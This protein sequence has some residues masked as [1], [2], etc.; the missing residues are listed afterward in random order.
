MSNLFQNFD[1]F[2]YSFPKPQ[3]LGAK[4]IHRK[5]IANEVPADCLTVLDAFA[6]SQS[7]AYSLKQMG[8]RVLTNDFLNFNSMMPF[9]PTLF[10]VGMNGILTCCV[11]LG[12]SV[13][14]RV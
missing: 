2:G 7:V 10:R 11:L 12:F 3:Y 6:G 1:F 5:W 14:Y 8:K 9:I 4:Y 13:H